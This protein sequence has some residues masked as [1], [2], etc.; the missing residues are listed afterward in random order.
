MSPSVI[1]LFVG[2]A[3]RFT[4]RLREALNSYGSE[5][6]ADTLR[7]TSR[8]LNHGALL[9]D[10]EAIAEA[11]SAL[12]KVA[13][14]LL[15]RK[16]EWTAALARKIAVVISRIDAVVD[17]LP[18]GDVTAEAA[19][20]GSVDELLAEPQVAVPP[21]TGDESAT[22]RAT[23]PGG[24]EADVELT[25][26]IEELAEAVDRLENDPRDREP[27]KSILR[28]IRRLR[29]LGEIQ[30][31][32]P[33]DKALSAVEELI[34]QIADLNATVG[35][36]Y[37]TVFRHAREVLEEMR[38]V[39]AGAATST[40]VG[41]HA[42]EVDRLKDHVMQTARRARVVI[43]VSELF[44]EDGPH[45]V[46]CP[47]AENEAGSVEA[48][49]RREGMRRLEKSQDLRE[50]MLAGTTEEMRLAGESLAHT[51]R[52]LRERAVAF[53]YADLGR[54]ARRAAAALRARLVRPPSRLRAMALAYGDLF[55]ALR[56]HV[57]AEDEA[58][59]GRSIADAERALEDAISEEEEEVSPELS[60][61]E[62]E[63]DP[64]RALQRAMSLRAR[65]DERL[66]HLGGPDAQGLRD[67]LEE[68]FDLVAQ[69]VSGS[70]GRH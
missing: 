26:L 27:L 39:R 4:S 47:L 10:Q 12:Q 18:A 28:R 59:R 69:F 51:L 30:L 20:H 62:V 67:D 19:L 54:I 50:Q 16:R 2:D 14:E 32:S 58:R 3:R 34:L 38:T 15:A 52:H 55:T 65:L 43:W 53:G 29:D 57:E 8:R 17:A 68:L 48:Y 36:G 24:R 63:V 66:K 37:L 23:A 60:E 5:P 6:D 21:A 7:R 35:P 61:V 44:Y 70:V 45:V 1:D 31:L 22:E 9:A 64:D 49:F 56:D 33:P 40:Q 11:A 46:S 41:D 42:V 13:L 25:A